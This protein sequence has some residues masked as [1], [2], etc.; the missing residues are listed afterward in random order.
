MTRKSMCSVLSVLAGI[1]WTVNEYV[2]GQ[3]IQRESGNVKSVK[4]VNH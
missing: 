3:L 1:T 4:I 2:T